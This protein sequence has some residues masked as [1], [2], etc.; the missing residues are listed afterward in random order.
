MIRTLPNDWEKRYNLRPVLI[1]SFVQKDRF[2]G[3]CY[4]GHWA[5]IILEYEKRHILIFFVI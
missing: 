3:T 2:A 1:E 5:R 4:K